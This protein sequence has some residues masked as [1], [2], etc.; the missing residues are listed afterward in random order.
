MGHTGLV[1]HDSSQVHRLLGVILSA[2]STS[3]VVRKMIFLA[4]FTHLGE[5]LDLSAMTGGTLPGEEAKGAMAGRFVLDDRRL[6]SVV[7]FGNTKYATDLTVT[8]EKRY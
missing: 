8:G 5:R 4:E 2:K 6:A 3:N 7:S 1:A